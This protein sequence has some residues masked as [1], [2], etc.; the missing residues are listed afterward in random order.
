MTNQIA[1]LALANARLT[2]ALAHWALQMPPNPH[3]ASEITAA[4]DEQTAAVVALRRSQIHASAEIKSEEIVVHVPQADWQQV[5]AWGE[6]YAEQVVSFGRTLT[7]FCVRYGNVK[8]MV[9]INPKRQPDLR[10][11]S[12]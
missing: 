4:I 9:D 1:E 2:A 12:E 3:M 11:A 5:L 10:A 8:L 7:P 6:K